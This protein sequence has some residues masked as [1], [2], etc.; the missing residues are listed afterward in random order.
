MAA[1]NRREETRVTASN[2]LNVLVLLPLTDEQRA[3]LEAGAPHARYTYVT[4][5][6]PLDVGAPSA[7][8]LIPI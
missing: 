2:P 7:L 3:R 4:P 8:A 1:K 5:T 6:S